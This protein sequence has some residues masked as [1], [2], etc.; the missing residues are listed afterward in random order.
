MATPLRRLRRRLS[1]RE[2]ILE[3]RLLSLTRIA[4]EGV[5]RVAERPDDVRM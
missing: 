1:H 2:R 5:G 3:T 4:A